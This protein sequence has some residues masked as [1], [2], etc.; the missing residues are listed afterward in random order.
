MLLSINKFEN[1]FEEI[2]CQTMLK[3][4]ISDNNLF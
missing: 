1:I 3:I 4:R 2:N